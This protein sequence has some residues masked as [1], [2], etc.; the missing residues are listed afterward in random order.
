MAASGTGIC[1]R[2]ACDPMPFPC[3]I[4]AVA[5]NTAS[6]SST[7]RRCRRATSTCG[8]TTRSPTTSPTGHLVDFKGM[9][10]DGSQGL[11]HHHRAADPDDNDTS[12]DLYMWNET[13]RLDH[14]DR[15]RARGGR[16]HRRLQ[17]RPGSPGAASRSPH[18]KL[19]DSIEHAAPPTTSI[20]TTAGDV[21][22]YSPE[23]FVGSNGIPGRRNLYVYRD[24]EIQ[25]VA[26][27][28]TEQAG[29]AGSRSRPDGRYAAFITAQPADRATTTTGF[30]EMYRYDAETRRPALR[31]LPAER[32]PADR[33]TSKAA[34]TAST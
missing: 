16:Q 33:A 10:A 8:S 28:D 13:R 4:A 25:Y 24:G 21:Y 14:P 20:A 18:P 32:R 2:A 6:A 7:A 11:L 17:R 12:T 23:Q 34:R 31:L 9:T 15:R 1:G 19:R 29:D 3:G 27:L 22:F 30:V 26:T 5:S